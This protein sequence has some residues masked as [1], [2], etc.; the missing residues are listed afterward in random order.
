MSVLNSNNSRILSGLA[1]GSTGCLQ[2]CRHPQSDCLA[3]VL[4]GP[5]MT[6]LHAV[7]IKNSPT[8]II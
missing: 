7:T 8:T 4:D 5:D 3:R 2:K 1:K 6:V